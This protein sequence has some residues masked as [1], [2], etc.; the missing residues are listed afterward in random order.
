MEHKVIKWEIF[1]LRSMMED[2]KALS[3]SKDKDFADGDTWSIHTI[4]LHELE[5]LEGEVKEHAMLEEGY[6]EE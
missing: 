6:E 4:V 2:T 1:L 5:H 3:K